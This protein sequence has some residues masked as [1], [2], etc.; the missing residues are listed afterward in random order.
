[1]CRYSKASAYVEVDGK[2][3]DHNDGPTHIAARTQILKSARSSPADFAQLVSSPARSSTELETDI[4]AV[5]CIGS[6]VHVM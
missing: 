5:A 1:M 2:P 6:H 3:Y 4:V